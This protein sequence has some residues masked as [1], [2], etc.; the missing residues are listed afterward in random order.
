MITLITG[1]IRSGKSRFAVKLAG[2]RASGHPKCFL[3][4]A[5]ALDME[6]KFRI[7][8]HQKERGDHFRTIEEPIYLARA[9]EKAQKEF[10]LLLVDCLTLWVN[11]LLFHL[12]GRPEEIEREIEA[13]I[14]VV[15]LK[16]ARMIFVTNEVGLGV[17][18][19]KASARRYIDLLGKVN[20]ELAALS[21]EVIFMVSGI[22]NFIKEPSVAKLDT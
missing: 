4:T 13:L 20:Q 5:Q 21:D 9:V 16:D 6:M 3:A 10:H 14:Q 8:N 17:I 19:D 12:D 1:G 2:E 15:R 22:P 7:Q 11:N 18:P